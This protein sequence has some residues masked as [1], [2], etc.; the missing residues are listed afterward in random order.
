MFDKSHLENWINEEC[1]EEEE[2]I[3]MVVKVGKW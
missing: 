3:I 2:Y 1:A